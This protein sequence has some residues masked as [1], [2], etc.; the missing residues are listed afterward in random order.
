MLADLADR[1]AQ[2]EAD[3]Q[4]IVDRRDAVAATLHELRATLGEALGIIASD[5]DGPQRPD[6]AEPAG[7]EPPD[8]TTG[9]LAPPGD[10][11]GG[12]PTTGTGSATPADSGLTATPADPGPTATPADSGLIATPAGGA[13]GDADTA[14]TLRGEAD[15]EPL[16]SSLESSDDDERPWPTSFDPFAT[17]DDDRV[18]DSDPKEARGPLGDD[19][20]DFDSRFEA[21]VSGTTG[22]QHFRS[23]F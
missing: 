18:G 10:S 19:D 13:A 12:R 9:D 16:S 17:P 5:R 8:A 3:V 23:R 14:A 7:V 1:R 22:P 15:G 20:G 6:A 4:S 21:W 11:P 2:A